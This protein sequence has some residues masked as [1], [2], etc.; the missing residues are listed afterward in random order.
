MPTETARRA[1]GSYV[2]P[3]FP[4]GVPGVA[5][6]D[7]DK[8]QWLAM[9]S[10]KRSYKDEVIAKIKALPSDFTVEQYGS[11]SIDPERY[12]L[13]CVKIGNDSSKPTILVTGG[14][15]GYETSGVQ[16]ALVFVKDHAK[17]YSDDFNIVVA[18]CVSPWG[19]GAWRQTAIARPPFHLLFLIVSHVACRVHSA[20]DLHNNR[21]E[22][23]LCAASPRRRLRGGSPPY[24][25]GQGDRRRD[26]PAH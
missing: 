17:N 24:E 19:Y 5:W 11:L 2:A 15:H 7:S 10:V 25:D 8:A 1:A 23:V 18:P 26:D 6:G 16:G 21:P 13:F 22:Q 4:V 20:L 9:Q 3:F 12:P 14:V